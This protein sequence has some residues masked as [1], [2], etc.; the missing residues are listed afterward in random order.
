LTTAQYP[1]DGEAL[2]RTATPVQPP[3]TP[4]RVIW[5]Y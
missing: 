2:A 3:I 5:E 4:V 1:W